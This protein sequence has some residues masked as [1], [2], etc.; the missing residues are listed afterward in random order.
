[1]FCLNKDV[2]RPQTKHILQS[3]QI[4][5][6]RTSLDT[7][8]AL[9]VWIKI[10]FY[11]LHYSYYFLTISFDHF[12]VKTQIWNNFIC[13]RYITECRIHKR[14]LQRS[15][16]AAWAV[17]DTGLQSS[18]LCVPVIAFKWYNDL[19]NIPNLVFTVS[20]EVHLSAIRSCFVHLERIL[21]TYSYLDSHGYT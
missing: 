6:E 18:G 8:T 15:A 1:M 16:W 14:E 9:L 10:S 21:R 20:S 11:Q 13:A 17:T 12:N 5:S 7:F 19:Y 4:F 3:M 2:S